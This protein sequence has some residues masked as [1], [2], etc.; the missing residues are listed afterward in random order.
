MAK[1]SRRAKSQNGDSSWNHVTE[2]GLRSHRRAIVVGSRPLSGSAPAR[3]GEIPAL[4][5]PGVVLFFE[6]E[7]LLHLSVE[8]AFRTAGLGLIG[9]LCLREADH[10]LTSRPQALCALVTDMEL[11]EDLTGW[12]LARRARLVLPR[13][14]VIYASGSGGRDFAAEAVTDAR[15][16]SKPYAPDHLAKVNCALMGGA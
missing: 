16:I 15:F 4:S 1:S 12:A 10:L 8:D 5:L 9:V 7:A 2:A 6:D 14:P 11:G 13:L 3:S